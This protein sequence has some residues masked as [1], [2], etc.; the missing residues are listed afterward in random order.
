MKFNKVK[1][2]LISVLLLSVI[3]RLYRIDKNPVSL[4]GDEIDVGYQA[5][6]ILK[7]GRDYS[8]NFLPLHFRS[9]AEWRT[10]FYIY[11]AVPT[12]GIFG[13]S[14]LGVRL[15]AAIFGILSIWIIFVLA[16]KIT[17]NE[18]IALAS[19]SFLAISPWHLQYSRA[20]FEV[21]EMLFFYMTG[22]YFFLRGL[23]TGKWFF[24]AAAF[25]G[26][27]PWIY[28]TAKL[29]IPLTIIALLLIWWK[30]LKEV[31]KG[32]LLGSVLIFAVITGTFAFNT[33]FGGGTQRIEGIS[34]FND[35]T[36]VPQIGFDRLADIKMRNKDAV[37]TKQATFIDKFFH[38]QPFSF[39]NIFFEN[40][41][42][43]YSTEFLFTKGDINP[44]HSIGTGEFYKVQA[45]FLLLGLIFLLTRVTDRKIKIF[46]VF[47]LLGGSVPSAF[48]KDGGG[49]A[50]RLILIL[51]PLILLISLG[52]YHTYQYLSKNLRSLFAVFFSAL[53]FSNF[54]FYQ[55]RFWIHYPWESEKWWHAGFKD[56]IRASVS[57]G[58]NYDKVIISQADEPALIFFLG[59]SQ[60]PPKSFQEK[61]PLITENT[62]GFGSI[63]K[64]DKYYFPPVGQ[65]ISMYE[66]GSV[67][68]LKTLYLATF[69]EINLDLIREPE[70]IPKDINLIKSI[71][72]PSGNPAFYLFA[73]R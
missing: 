53:L 5:Y 23:K 48:T 20:G 31:S 68:P 24:L 47:W 41:F 59:W 19:A 43:V 32:Y 39:L 46:L 38:N 1:F 72:Y 64:L 54:I 25:L 4:F 6:S 69:K 65:G 49:H 45:P 56:A 35:P 37:D 22:I 30:Q 29:F 66:L 2:L 67:L 13:I 12:V 28:S 7:T 27:T 8:G 52:V 70:R 36:V 33:L 55:H 60:Y 16:K 42:Q 61:Y 15:P 57:E 71:Q 26:L 10:P 40:L 73:K 63:S 17:N 3:L 21:T 58:K 11:S 9:L 51:P 18:T 62:T 34:I 14:P 44:R 50:T